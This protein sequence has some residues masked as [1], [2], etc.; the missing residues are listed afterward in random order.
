MEYLADVVKVDPS[1]RTK[2]QWRSLGQHHAQALVARRLPQMDAF[3]WRAYLAGVRAGV[4]HEQKRTIGT[5][6]QPY[7]MAFVWTLELTASNTPRVLGK[8]VSIREVA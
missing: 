6:E 8:R 5:R 4:A 7:W 1:E 3:E 2:E